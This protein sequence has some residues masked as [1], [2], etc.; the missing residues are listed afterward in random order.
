M[1]AVESGEAALC[2]GSRCLAPLHAC[3]GVQG[4]RGAE[5]TRGA[6]WKRGAE[7]TR[8]AGE[9]VR[10]RGAIAPRGMNGRGT[11]ALRPPR[12]HSPAASNGAF[13]EG[14][15][16]GAAL[17]PK[18]A[19]GRP[20]QSFLDFFKDL[21]APPGPSPAATAA[22]RV[23]DEPIRQDGRPPKHAPPPGLDGLP[24]ARGAAG[25]C[26]PSIAAA[27][28]AGGPPPLNIA[29]VLDIPESQ[30]P[31]TALAGTKPKPRPRAY[32]PL[33]RPALAAS[34]AAPSSAPAG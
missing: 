21:L 5:W 27:P 30:P 24:S 10:Q 22:Q 12:S 29:T 13:Q 23:S 2:T 20:A 11:R 17:N 34:S 19:V 8:G 32:N 4:A 3:A 25:G 15:G 7:W 1:Q 6:E 9:N 18:P 31:P 28:G 26:P 14:W 33:M 16:G